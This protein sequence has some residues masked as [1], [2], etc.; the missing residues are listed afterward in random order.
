MNLKIEIDAGSGFCFG[1]TTAIRKAEEE[2]A[3]GKTLYCLGDIVHNGMEVERLHNQGL[4]TIDHEQL[5]QLHHAKVLLRAHGEP[6][7]TYEVARQND[8][9]IIDATCPV[10]LALQRNTT[11]TRR[12]KS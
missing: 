7:S 1:V 5:K 2:L 12:P 3:A 6:P 9:E 4:V 11:T 10:V 8:I